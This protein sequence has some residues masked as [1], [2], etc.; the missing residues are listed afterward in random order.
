MDVPIGDAD[1]PRCLGDATVADETSSTLTAQ[2]FLRGALLT[3]PDGCP[4]CAVY[5][6]ANPSGGLVGRDK[7]LDLPTHSI[8]GGGQQT[9]GGEVVSACGAAGALLRTTADG[10]SWVPLVPASARAYRPVVLVLLSE[11][12]SGQRRAVGRK[13]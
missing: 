4:A 12:S 1:I 8:D 13:G 5:G 9:D 6:E 7:R 3:G 10:Q 2:G 11:R